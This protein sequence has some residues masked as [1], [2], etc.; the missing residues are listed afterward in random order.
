MQPDCLLTEHAE[1]VLT[2]TLNRPAALNSLDSHLRRRLLD[3]LE[4][5]AGSPGVT[6]ILLRGAGRGFCAGADLKEA[7]DGNGLASPQQRADHVRDLMMAEFNPIIERIAAMPK[8]VVAAVHGMA[9]G[10]GVGLAL[11]CDIVL[12]ATSARFYQ[13]FVPALGL[14]PDMGCTWF[15]TAAAGRARALAWALT[16]DIISAATALEWGLIWKLVDSADLDTEAQALARQL[17]GLAPEAVV[18]TRRALS[19]ATRVDLSAQLH[20]EMETQHQLA[21]LPNYHEGV[22][23]FTGSK[24]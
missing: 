13:P 16:G 20:H 1:G 17:S 19:H 21:A 2:L 14:V 23:R 3:E 9:A 6:A 5:A 18:A 10:G 8:P 22:Q 4:T 24:P 12:C 7:A 15:V 11:A